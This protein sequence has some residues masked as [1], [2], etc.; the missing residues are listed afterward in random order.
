MRREG[1]ASGRGGGQWREQF[2]LRLDRDRPHNAK[3]S[4]GRF[5]P[6]QWISHFKCFLHR[7]S[8]S[9]IECLYGNGGLFLA[10]LATPYACFCATSQAQLSLGS[11]PGR[12][13]RAL[14][15]DFNINSRSVICAVGRLYHLRPRI[16][17]PVRPA[18]PERL[19][20]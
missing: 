18:K 17:P 11:G 9:L 7:S 1:V 4:N 10:E 16:V 13:W 20:V 19:H 5:E 2:Q 3:S 6:Y 15:V 14:S 8:S 12:W